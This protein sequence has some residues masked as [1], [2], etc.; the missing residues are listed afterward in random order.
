MI[1]H[2]SILFN[3]ASS[4]SVKM[5]IF[6]Y[7]ARFQAP[8]EFTKD[9]VLSQ[10]RYTGMLETIRIRKL[11]YHIRYA[12]SDFHL[13]FGL[14]LPREMKCEQLKDG[15]R[16]VFDKLELHPDHYRLG[17]T[18]VLVY[19]FFSQNLKNIIEFDF[20]KYCFRS[21]FYPK[22]DGYRFDLKNDVFTQ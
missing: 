2:N 5:R 9:L 4:L 19:V 15:L 22:K 7:F 16:E 13:I 18:K 20:I 12:Y 1:T 14:L 3:M 17:E 10:L 21:E 11:G 8:L 6:F